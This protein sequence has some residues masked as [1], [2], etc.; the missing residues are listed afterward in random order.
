MLKV[1]LFKKLHTLVI[2]NSSL[3]RI[4]YC[5]YYNRMNFI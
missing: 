1:S 3:F 5:Y 2:H 4:T